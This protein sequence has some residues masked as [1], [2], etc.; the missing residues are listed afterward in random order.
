MARTTV[1]QPQQAEA[2]LQRF[3]S[4]TDMWINSLEE[5]TRIKRVMASHD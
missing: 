1:T 4:H 2:L 3:G 5:R